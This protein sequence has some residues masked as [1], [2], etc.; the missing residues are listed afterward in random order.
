M[1][2]MGLPIERVTFLIPAKWSARRAGRR[3][4]RV[5][6]DIR[7]VG[8]AVGFLRH[9]KVRAGAETRVVTD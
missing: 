9:L 2:S 8:F 7:R 6:Q 4:S 5:C 3:R 1:A